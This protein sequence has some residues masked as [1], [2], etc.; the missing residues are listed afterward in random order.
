MLQYLDWRSLDTMCSIGKEK[1]ANAIKDR[2]MPPARQLLYIHSSSVKKS[3]K[4]PKGGNQN[5]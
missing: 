1:V 4:I 5:T 3:L 2:P